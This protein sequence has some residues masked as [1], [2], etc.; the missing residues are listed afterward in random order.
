[1]FVENSMLADMAMLFERMSVG[2]I[3]TTMKENLRETTFNKTPKTN[4]FMGNSMFVPIMESERK[5]RGQAL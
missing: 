3:V 4:P 2:T 1:M 5:Q